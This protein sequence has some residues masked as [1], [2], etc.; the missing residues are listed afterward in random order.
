M[1]RALRKP[2]I[3]KLQ[4]AR[5]DRLLI[6]YITSTRPGFEIQI[7]DD[8]CRVIHNHLEAGKEL[9]KN[10]VDLFIHSNGGS[11]TAPWRIVSL[12]RQYCKDFTVLVPHHAFSAATLIA[13][14]ANSIV[15]HRMGCLGPIDPSVSN[16]FNPPHPV[17]PGQTAPIS[18][19][20][21]TAYF[22]LVK[23]DVGITHEDELV[24]ALIAL[25]DKIHPLAVGN[26][27]RHHSQSRLMARRL[28]ALHMKKS[29]AHEMEKLIDTM[30]SNLF[31]HGHPIN[32]E[33]AKEDLGL[34]AEKPSEEVEA[35]MWELY[36][37]YETDM[38]L[39]IPFVPLREFELKAGTPAQA[40]PPTVAQ[41]V[42][43]MQGLAAAGVGLPAVTEVQLVKLAAALVPLVGGTASP[44]Q[45]VA[46]DPLIG[47]YVESAARTDVFRIEMKVERS[48]ANVGGNVQDVVKQEAVPQQWEEET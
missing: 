24:K 43:Q 48:T 26:V 19:E 38:K 46:I 14:G 5:K 1:S 23:D 30:K 44:L 32:R 33:E 6:S 40:G 9:A 15:M 12:I 47:A 18:V 34:K 28:L 22:K 37:A 29:E 16:I 17:Q 8:A 25:T 27:H 2:I 42:Q 31:F 4:T 10:G 13:L 3:E 39:R 11:G 7:A 20:D 45:K 35:L 21:V 41:I 36:S